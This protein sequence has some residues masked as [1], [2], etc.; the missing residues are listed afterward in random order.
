MTQRGG[1]GVDGASCMEV[2]RI[3]GIR[4]EFWTFSKKVVKAGSTGV[5]ATT[6]SAAG[7]SSM[8]VG[9]AAGSSI[10]IRA[11]AG[12]ALAASRCVVRSSTVRSEIDGR[13]HPW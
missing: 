11:G 12:P 7:V 8:G 3:V 5:G 4:A 2:I 1:A 10:L 9:S 13:V 6:G